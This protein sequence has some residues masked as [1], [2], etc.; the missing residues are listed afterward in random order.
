MNSDTN[1]AMLLP[2]SKDY[3]SRL[4]SV[5]G[6]IPL[7]TIGNGNLLKEKAV[8]ICGSRNASEEALSYAYRFGIEAAKQDI[9]VVSGYARGIDRQAHLGA[10][11]AGGAT[12]AVL[13]QGIEHF[14]L[15]RDFRGLSTSPE[16][17]SKFLVVSMFER[18]APWMPWRAM[19]RNKLIV[20]LSNAM[21]VVEARAKGGTMHAAKECLRQKKPLWVVDYEPEGVGREGSQF[22]LQ[23]NANPIKEIEDFSQAV[24][25]AV[26]SSNE[27][28]YQPPLITH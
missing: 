11:H 16:F 15:V 14:S 13:P 22:L 1:V 12:I 24:K 8:G 4:N 5:L 26:T 25:K 2:E 23:G 7:Y 18:N 6:R 3:P 20:G 28:V 17:M 27:V 19:T 10:L 21:F 9:V